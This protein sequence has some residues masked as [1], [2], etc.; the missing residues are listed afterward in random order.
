VLTIN[1]ANERAETELKALEAKMAREAAG[2]GV[3][4]PACGTINPPGSQRCLNC[5]TLL[6]QAIFTPPPLPGESAAGQES[7][8]ESSPREVRHKSFMEML[9]T[10]A[11]MFALPKQER[12][13]EEHTYARWGL[14]VPGILI[15]SGITYFFA[16]LTNVGTSVLL[17]GGSPNWAQLLPCVCGGAVGGAV[18]GLVSFFFNSGLF[19]LI[20]RLFTGKGEFVVQSYLLSLVYGPFSLIFGIIS[21]LMLLAV[22]NPALSLIPALIYIL[23][24][25]LALVMSVRAL[26]SAHGYGTGA[27]LGTIFLPGIFFA[28]VG[29]LLSVL[30]A[31]SLQTTLPLTAPRFPAA[32]TESPPTPIQQPAPTLPVGGEPRSDIPVPEE[33]TIIV[34]SAAQIQYDIFQSPAAV[35]TYYKT[36]MPLQGWTPDTP[37]VVE[38]ERVLLSYSKPGASVLI[39]ASRSGESNPTRVVIAISEF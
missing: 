7:L 14:V 8:G 34:R 5:Y 37:N 19:Y 3:V 11:E 6:D 31:G 10:W 1:P 39:Q 17:P 13:D 38:A 29:G 21:P 12:L 16:S 20:A 15:A 27:A 18:M 4:C 24:A 2:S 30:L 26:K 32:I 36:Q 25:I 35:G 28:C 22:I 23:V 9:D 33:A